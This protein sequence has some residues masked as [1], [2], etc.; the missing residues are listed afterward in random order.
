MFFGMMRELPLTDRLT[1][2]TPDELSYPN[3]EQFSARLR[4]LPA[5]R[6]LVIDLRNV[7]YIDSSGLR[8]LILEHRR[9]VE[10]G[11]SLAVT[12]PTPLV[13]RLLD[14]TGI[15]RVLPVR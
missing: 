2:T 1:V 13:V 14:L 11:G 7:P 6:E 3:A 10:A 15:G 5:G 9:R 8:A 12:N 4:G